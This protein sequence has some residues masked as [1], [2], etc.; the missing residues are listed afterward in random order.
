MEIQLILGPNN[1]GKSKYAEEVAVAGGDKLIYLATM[2]P[3]NE[4]NWKKIEK[5]RIQRQDKGFQTI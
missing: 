1:S 2:I 3:Q 4:N 5:H